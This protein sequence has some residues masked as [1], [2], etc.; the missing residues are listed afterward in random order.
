MGVGMGVRGSVHSNT[1]ES[2]VMPVTANEEVGDRM[3]G[4][5][6]GDEGEWEELKVGAS[7]QNNDASKGAPV[8]IRC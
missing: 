7:T 6:G 8:L 5:E 4:D 2:S 3:G 1:S